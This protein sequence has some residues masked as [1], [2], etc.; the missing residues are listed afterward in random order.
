MK[1]SRSPWILMTVKEG[2]PVDQREVL[3]HPALGKLP[4]RK[5]LHCI[6]AL[7]PTGPILHFHQEQVSTSEL[8]TP[9]PS[10]TLYTLTDTPAAE[11]RERCR[12]IPPF[13]REFD[14]VDA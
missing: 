2:S 13:V 11:G 8:P 14:A 12:I 9:G 7:S 3:L 5:V 10:G 1:K 4:A 6:F